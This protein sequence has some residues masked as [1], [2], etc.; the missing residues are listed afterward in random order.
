MFFICWEF[1]NGWSWCSFRCLF[2]CIGIYFVIY[3]KNINIFFIG[4]NMINVVKF[5]I[6]GLIIVVDNLLICFY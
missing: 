6:I 4:K 3:N 1:G 5:D 2:V